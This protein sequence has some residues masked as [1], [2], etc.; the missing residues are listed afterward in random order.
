MKYLEAQ[1]VLG[2][3]FDKPVILLKDAIEIFNLQDCN[4]LAVPRVFQDCVYSLCCGQIGSAFIN[5][6]FV[7]NTVVTMAFLKKRRVAPGFQRS[8]SMKSS[9][10]PSRSTAQYG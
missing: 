5:D 9:V 8:E 1:H 7:W 2:N 6:N 4:H 3:P 10:G